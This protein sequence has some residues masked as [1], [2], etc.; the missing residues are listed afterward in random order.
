[1]PDSPKTIVY[2]RP[3]TIG[4][5]V[6]FTPALGLLMAEWPKARH[7]IVV[8]EGYES[9][10][11]LFPK[12]V[13]WQVAR[14]NPFKQ[15]PSE[16]RKALGAL[17]ATL[18]GIKP[19]LILAP[20]LNR[21]WLE[22]AVAAHFKDVRSV[23]LGDAAVDPIFA[24]SLR[25]DLGVDSAKT[26]KE[27]VP[28]DKSEGEV[29]GQ[30]RFAESLRRPEA[31]SGPAHCRDPPR[32]RPCRQAAVLAKHGLSR[33]DWV[34]VFPGGGA[35]VPLKSWPTEKFAEIVA[36]LGKKEKMRV[37]LLGQ[38]DEA[39]VLDQVSAL[40]VKLGAPK[41]GIWLGKDGELPLLAALLGESN[42]YL[43]N[44]TGAMHLAAAT[45][46]PVIG[47]FGGGTWPRF[48]PSARQAISVVQPL[49]CFGCNWDCHFGDA[50][51]VKT[52]PVAD[53]IRAVET[54]LSGGDKAIE[55][56]IE[57]H[58]LPAETL[59]LIEA[60]AP[61]IAALKRD[62]VG[63]QHKI[64]ELKAETDFKDVEIGELKRA[65]E[66]RKTEME[67]IKAEL[68]QECADKDK[69]IDELKAETNTKDTEM[70]DLK[71]AAEE[72]KTE[73]EAIKSELEQECA[74][75]DKEIDELKAEA[76][77]KD[78][79]IEALKVTCDE[80]EAIVVRLDGRP[81]GPPCGGGRMGAPPVGV[82]V[83]AGRP[84][85]EARHAGQAPVGPDDLGPD[86]P[87]QGR[88]HR[89]YREHAEGP[90]RGDRG[91]APDD[92]QLRVGP[93]L[94]RAGK[95]LRTAPLGEGGGGPG[96]LPHVRRARGRHQGA[97]RRGDDRD[98]APS[99]A[100]D[101]ALRRL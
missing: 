56:T 73:M 61:G 47:I 40:A 43:G 101:R 68:E 46:R 21:T 74:D 48:R 10:A 7:V 92:L 6:L 14:L 83:R 96:A 65:A 51:C 16:C 19:D 23:A 9:I 30:H 80:R 89:Q 8:R 38:V 12:G 28:S 4:D 13:E 99:K 85:L 2:L 24:E 98:L 78:T 64:E 15:R 66:E 53:V 54:L 39:G 88:P 45:G 97:G 63:R 49:P 70:G 72:R 35:N 94:N 93:R 87:A 11:P 95:A 86:G 50:P 84:Y 44:D 18:D 69:E 36:R 29:Q 42:F 52:I 79:E 60:T 71:R 90:R 17:F 57:S 33:G 34:A 37:L 31:R 76:T 100:L 91:A 41:P 27:T 58:A 26:F 67:A 5:L 62:R 25:L 75:K 77:T 20:T 55:S 81:E 22:V 82:G 59:R 3:D 1:M 32:R